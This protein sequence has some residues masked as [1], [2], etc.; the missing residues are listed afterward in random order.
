MG[1]IDL[2]M[3]F[4]KK[5]SYCLHLWGDGNVLK[6]DCLGWPVGSVGSSMVL[7]NI[8]VAGSIPA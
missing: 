2:G 8:K 5:P 3:N 4:A 6:L 7:I 1:H